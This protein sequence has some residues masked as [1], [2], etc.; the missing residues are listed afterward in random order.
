MRNEL[1]SNT[2]PIHA[3][4]GCEKIKT[5][6]QRLD[7]GSE[8]M[9]SI[10]D[11]LNNLGTKF[12]DHIKLSSETNGLVNEVLGILHAGKGFFKIMG[13]IATGIKW[14][15]AFVAPVLALI[16]TIKGGGKP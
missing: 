4:G 1:M 15:A 13:Y 2:P 7:I 9:N 3:P 16:Y 14:T 6:E 10:E 8:R 11:S 12:D 5:V